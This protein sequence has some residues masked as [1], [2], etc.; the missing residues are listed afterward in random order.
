MFIILLLY[1]EWH[2]YILLVHGCAF[3]VLYILY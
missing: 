2:G 3:V 1:I